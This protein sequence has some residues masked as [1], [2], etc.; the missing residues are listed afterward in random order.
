MTTNISKRV[1]MFRE[2]LGMTQ[3]A[4]S[5]RAGISQAT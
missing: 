5:Q 1:K 2:N 3:P 4:A